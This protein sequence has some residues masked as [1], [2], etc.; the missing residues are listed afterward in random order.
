MAYEFRLPDIGEGVAEGEVVRWFVREGETVQEDAPLVSVL[1]DKANVEIPSPRSG[2]VLKIHAQVGEK[3]KVGGLLVTIE[4]AGGAAPPSPATGSAAAPPPGPSARPPSPP[5]PSSA[6]AAPAA[7]GPS[8]ASPY[9]RRL[10]AERG[11]D[12]AKVRGS[13]PG[14][15]VVE[16]DV[17]AAPSPA[18]PSGGAAAPS[19]ASGGAPAAAPSPRP[20][21]APPS[22]SP[23][24]PVHP[25]PPDAEVLERVPIRGIRRVIAEHMTE[26][27]HRAAH[28]TYVEEIDASE[29]VRLRERMAKHVEKQGTRLTYLPFVL[30][31]V[32]AGLKA[33]PRLNATMD[34]EHG[35]LLVRSAYHL[36]IATAAPDGLLVPVIRHADRRSIGQLARDIQD[37]AERGRAGKLER[38]ELS[39]S[40]F[41]ITSLG[42]LG[43]VLAT[44]ILN[45]PEVAI[46]GVHKIQ[47][48]PVYRADGTIGP[49]DLMNL[50]ISL[51]HRVL[52]GYEGA[53]FLATVKGYLEDPHQMFAE[54]A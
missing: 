8:L 14:G 31:G 30:K 17:V 46:L 52:D 40:T 42:A 23:G 9:V 18:R 20:G 6:P 38:G 15:R 45:Y 27:T 5:S 1:T 21:G 53:Q 41:T 12:L 3:V 36:G 32:L 7:S 24:G 44:P 11:V 39:G 35:E 33:H 4:A 43:G 28:F 10:A 37:L 47:R 49:A 34:D 2:K 48:R 25:L 19:P 16:S 26:A 54:L 50:S 13:G 22:P 29:L 51:D